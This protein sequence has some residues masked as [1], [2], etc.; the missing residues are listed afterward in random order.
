[1]ILF[2][3]I[4]YIYTHTAAPYDSKKIQH[5]KKVAYMCIVS[6]DFIVII[7]TVSYFIAKKLRNIKYF[8]LH[9]IKLLIFLS[10]NCLSKET[11]F[12]MNEF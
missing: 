2:Y 8:S 9:N 10:C 12:Q 11:E 5:V 7:A 3:K 6:F 1:M 4:I